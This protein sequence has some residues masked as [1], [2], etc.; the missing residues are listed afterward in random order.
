[1]WVRQCHKPPVRENRKFIPPIKMMMTG[2]WFMDVYGIVL[3]HYGKNTNKKTTPNIPPEPPALD[4]PS[5]WVQ[6]WHQGHQNT[7]AN[8]TS[9]QP[10]FVS[11]CL[12]F[13]GQKNWDNG[14]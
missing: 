8:A 6:L 4:P 5:P 1:M 14:I 3:R 11:K 13:F 9:P 2:G 7:P 10:D 12:S